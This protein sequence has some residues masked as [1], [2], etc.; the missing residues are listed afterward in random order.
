MPAPLPRRINDARGDIKAL[1]DYCT[2]V[3][4][5]LY[6]YLRD[7]E[8][9]L[10][11]GLVSATTDALL[12]SIKALITT[13]NSVVSTAALQT[14]GNTKLDTLHTDLNTYLPPATSKIAQVGSIGTA[15]DVQ[16]STQALVKGMWVRNSSTAGQLLYISMSATPTATNGWILAPGEITP[17]L[18]CIN[19]TAVFMR[20]SAA[21]GA[22]SYF[23]S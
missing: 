11:V 9:R 10:V 14:T 18:D 1:N 6:A 4:Y 20:A 3:S 15:A 17:F 7:L 16:F 13:L 8:V 21:S 5:D 23:G 2:G 22:A 12:T 19:A